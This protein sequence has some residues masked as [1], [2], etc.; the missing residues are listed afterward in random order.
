V[1]FRAGRMNFDDTTKRVIADKRKGLIQLVQ[2]TDGLMH[3]YWKDRKSGQ[4]ESDLII[5]PDE[6]IFKRVKQ[7][8]GRVYLLEFK[9]SSRKLFFWMQDQSDA[10]DE[11]NSNKLNQCMNNPPMPG[12]SQSAGVPSGPDQ[13]ALLQMLSGGRQGG[14]SRGG[15]TGG[16]QAASQP[17]LGVND[18][19]SILSGMGVPPSSLSGMLGRQSGQTAPTQRTAPGAAPAAAPATGAQ[20]PRQRLS[21][22]INPEAILPLLNNPAVQEQLIPFLPTERRTPEELRQVL[23][24]PQFQQSLDAFGDALESGQLTELLRQFGLQ[25]NG[26]T[27]IQQFLQAIQNSAPQGGDKKDDKMDTK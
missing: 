12:E 9:T 15:A 1:E 5:F 14:S 13:N 25:V 10:K 11:E 24:S 7:A 6:A 26:P 17:V 27:S 21:Q 3:F 20:A 4:N 16:S 8:S 18:L 2:A 22:L 19:Q 23:H